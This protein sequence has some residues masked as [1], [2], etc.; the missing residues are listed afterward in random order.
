ES[1]CC[2]DGIYAIDTNVGIER[3][4]VTH[5]RAASIIATRTRFD[6]VD[7]SLGPTESQASDGFYG[8]G[9]EANQGARVTL[10]RVHIARSRDIGLSGVLGAQIIARDLRVEDTER[11]ECA[12]SA[13][14]SEATGVAI[15]SFANS[16]LSLTRFEARRGALCG[17]HVWD[18]TV[19][20]REG[21][22]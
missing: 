1:G 8:R 13:C 14:R 18:S 5:T 17:V 2:G 6:A 21:T 16:S 19:S 10:E 12:S 11:P 15:G 3:A 7:L 9:F 4:R 22:I 20:L